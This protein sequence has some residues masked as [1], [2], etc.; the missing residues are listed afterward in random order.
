M[1]LTTK[2]KQLL[3]IGA[4]VTGVLS[5][6]SAVMIAISYP[7]AK[8]VEVARQMNSGPDEKTFQALMGS[9]ETT[10]T[11][12]IGMASVVLQLIL[13]VVAIVLTYR[14]IRKNR[15]TNNPAGSTAAIVTVASVVAGI[16]GQ[17]VD[18]AYGT[19]GLQLGIGFVLFGTVA[20]IFISFILAF[21]IT[22]IV[23]K[24]YDRKH[25]FAVE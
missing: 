21:V 22:L 8:H 1:K 3:K 9:S 4:A 19:G 12:A 11:I 16:V 10:W 17:L 5:A 6:V 13:F 20:N 7:T 14:Y 23:E 15:L 18:L 2:S 25:S 24:N